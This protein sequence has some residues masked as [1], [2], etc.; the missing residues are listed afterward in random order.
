MGKGLISSKWECSIQRKLVPKF[1]TWHWNQYDEDGSISQ[2][3]MYE[4][5]Y[6]IKDLVQDIYFVLSAILKT[7]NI[8]IE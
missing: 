6:F 4:D 2:F 1:S 5:G 7:K 8:F 3:G